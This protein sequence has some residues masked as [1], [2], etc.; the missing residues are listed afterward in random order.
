M[1]RQTI[2]ADARV[3]NAA[4]AS[5]AKQAK[6]RAAKR[7]LLERQTVREKSGFYAGQT[8]VAS[9]LTGSRSGIRPHKI[10][11]GQA[12]GRFLT[13]CFHATKGWRANA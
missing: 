8:T 1:R 9:L 4:S 10:R 6:R 2:R 3:A 7:A 11:K 13:E 5:E 12:F